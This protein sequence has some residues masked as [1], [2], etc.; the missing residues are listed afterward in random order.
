MSDTTYVHE[1]TQRQGLRVTLT[2]DAAEVRAMADIASAAIDGCVLSPEGEIDDAVL[3]NAEN[4]YKW[5]TKA[6]NTL[7]YTGGIR[8]SDSE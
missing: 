4:V 3:G 1:V 8:N 2:M 5:A 6:A 7:E